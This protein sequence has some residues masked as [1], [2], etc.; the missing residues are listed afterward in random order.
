MKGDKCKIA[1][2]KDHPTNTWC[3]C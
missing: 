1:F 2:A 3:L